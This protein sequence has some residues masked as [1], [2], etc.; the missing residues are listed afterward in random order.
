M[1]G[2]QVTRIDSSSCNYVSMS[3]ALR[4]THLDREIVMCLYRHFK[5]VTMHVVG[6][7]ILRGVRYGRVVAL[8]SDLSDPKPKF[9]VSNTVFQI[10]ARTVFFNFQGFV[11]PSFLADAILS[12]CSDNQLIRS[13][14]VSKLS[15]CLVLQ[16][17][18]AYFKG[19]VWCLTYSRNS[20]LILAPDLKKSLNLYE[21]YP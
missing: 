10:D 21:P 9:P 19:K 3:S 15:N 8:R 2:E 12:H 14:E 16:R 17:R 4:A 20:T 1:D 18:C 6:T 11:I 7:L 5:R 13:F